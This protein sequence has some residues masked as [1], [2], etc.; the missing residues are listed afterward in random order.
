[1]GAERLAQRI[2]AMS[3]RR[4]KI[5]VF[6]AGE[7]VPALGCM[8]AVM[9]G[10]AEMGHDASFYPVGKH[11]M[12]AALLA[13]PFGMTADDQAAWLLHGGGQA[14]WDELNDRFG[15]LSF[16]AGQSATR[17]FA[18]FRNPIETPDRFRGLRIRMP[19][20]GGHTVH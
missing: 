12:L 2:G 14:L 5:N 1:M 4:M 10:T 16:P 13:V 17:S 18:W 9:D 8:D 11:P 19:G 7:L 6:A 3:G 15:I 20:L